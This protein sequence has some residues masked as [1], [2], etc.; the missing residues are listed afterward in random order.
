[1]ITNN[2]GFVVAL[3]TR[4]RPEY[5][6]NLLFDLQKQTLIPSQYIFVENVKER[7]CLSLKKITSILK[8][9][10]TLYIKTLKNK[11][12]ALNICLKLASQDFI[13]IID[14]DIHIEPDTF[15][16]IVK[17]YK[18]LPN[19][20]ALSAKTLHSNHGVYS[21]FVNYWYNW[22]YLDKK[23][24]TI[25]PFPSTTILCLNINKLK[26]NSLSFNKKY[27]NGEDV[28]MYCQL[29]NH[30]LLSYYLPN[31]ISHHFFGDRYHLF[32]FLER[33]YQYGFDNMTISYRYPNLINNSWLVPSRKLHFIFLPI[34][35]V[36]NILKQ[37]NSIARD[38]PNFPFSLYPLTFLVFL[39]FDLGL[40]KSS[41]SQKKY[42]Y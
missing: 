30:H 33:F 15:E 16:K 41:L 21:S 6:D 37:I 39:S 27:K 4:N 13:I 42:Q 5:L 22:G 11:P 8:H 40:F 9:P 31:V 12:V 25:R 1:M 18:K 20:T 2:P 36:K 38:N 10:H 29:Q 19:A 32:S 3:C 24:P 35:L 7:Q 26:I 34:F 23:Q 14:D 28:D 17:A